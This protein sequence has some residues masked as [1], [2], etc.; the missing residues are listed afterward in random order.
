MLKE[1]QEKSSVASIAIYVLAQ[2]NA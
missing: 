2:G 1:K